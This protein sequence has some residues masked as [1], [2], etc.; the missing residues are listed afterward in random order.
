MK[1]IA[2]VFLFGSLFLAG[3]PE[4]DVIP[5]PTPKAELESHFEGVI[6]GVDVEFTENVD[7]YYLDATKLKV[8]APSPTPSTAVYYSQMRSGTTSTAILI[9]LGSISWDASL[10]DDPT[11][12]LFNDFFNASDDSPAPTYSLGGAA[13]FDVVYTDASGNAWHTKDT[14]Q[15]TVEFSAVSQESDDTGDYSKFICSF[16]CTVYRTVN[17]S[18]TDVE[19]SQEISNAVFKGWFKR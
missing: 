12:A 9:A 16:S 11:K 4:H 6:N 18:G 17:V 7:G 1:K 2:F 5:S 14:D 13:G 10:T 3:C 8:I 15:G 19:Y